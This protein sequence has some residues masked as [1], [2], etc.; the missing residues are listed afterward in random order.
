MAYGRVVFI[1]GAQT[2]LDPII[3]FCEGVKKGRIQYQDG[4]MPSSRGRLSD[5]EILGVLTQLFQFDSFLRREEVEVKFSFLGNRQKQDISYLGRI[6]GAEIDKADV[7]QADDLF[8]AECDALVYVPLDTTQPK[9]VEHL[10][11]LSMVMPRVRHVALTSSPKWN[12]SQLMAL[13]ETWTWLDPRQAGKLQSFAEEIIRINGGLTRGDLDKIDLPK[14]QPEAADPVIITRSDAFKEV[15]ALVD[16]IADTDSTVLISGE[17]GTG[18]ELI[19]NRIHARS[20][21][22][23]AEQVVV[24]CGAIPGEL[25]ESEL[26][27]HKKG[28]F[29]GANENRAGL[30]EIASKGTLLLDEIGD[31]PLELQVKL[32][33]VLQE[34]KI[35]RVGSSSEVE[36][37]ARIICATHKNLAKEVQDGNFREDLFYRISVF[38]IQLPA[39]RERENDIALLAQHFFEKFSS[40]QNRAG[41]RI[42]SEAMKKLLSHTWPGN[43][44]ELENTIERSIIMCQGSVVSEW[45]IILQSELSGDRQID[46]KNHN[47]LFEALFVNGYDLKKIEYSYVKFLTERKDLSKEQIAD[48]LG[49]NRK[50]LYRKEK[51]L[52][53]LTL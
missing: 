34:K 29:T 36:I 15:L 9:Q 27:G 18:K 1:L 39:L 51:E 3:H 14:E 19:A 46:T 24:N 7:L 53:E 31:L 35:R 47:S 32:L 52:E 30:F 13:K 5:A 26:F 25:L 33:R 21:R 38:P 37:D 2:G 41:L 50:T 49:I 40:N 23:K 43:V 12:H 22:A 20:H 28:A 4:A 11:R 48:H 44:R 42:S 8:N 16:A 6:F 10:A 45:D 17:S